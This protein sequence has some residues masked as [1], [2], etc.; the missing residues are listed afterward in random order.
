VPTGIFLQLEVD[1]DEDEDVAKLTR[2][3]RPGEARACRDLLVAMWRYCKRRKTD[4]HVSDDQLGRLA[5]P[6]SLR[7]AKRDAERLVECGIA[8][9]TPTGY[10]LPGFLK[11]NKSRAQIDETSAALA[12]SGSESGK[13]GNHVRHHVNK[14]RRNPA[15]SFCSSSGV[16]RVDPIGSDR[17]ESHIDRDIAI[18]RDTATDRDNRSTSEGGQRNETLRASDATERPDKPRCTRHQDVD[19]PPDCRGC[20]TAREAHEA[21]A[22][23]RKRARTDAA[24]SCRRCG[25]SGWIENA[26]GD[27]VAKCDHRPLLEVVGE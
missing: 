20:M 21:A 25:G 13:W 12:E 26:E 3:T 7:L 10:Y 14:G 5:Y 18:G 16:R 4:G 27:P 1:F 15:C 23:R 8:E 19:E 24:R 22:E 9:R 17:G 6:D 11:H 2:Y